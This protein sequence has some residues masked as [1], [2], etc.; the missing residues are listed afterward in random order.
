MDQPCPRLTGRNK[1]RLGDDR[2][3]VSIADRSGKRTTLTG[4][5]SGIQGLAWAPGGEEVWFTAGEARL[6]LRAVSLS[7]RQRLVTRAAGHLLIHDIAR[8]GRVLLTTYD[9]RA[10]TMGMAP[11]ETKERD[12]SSFEYSVLTDITPDGKKILYLE[13]GESGGS[14]YSV[15]LR[16]TDG[17]P[18]VRL[19]QGRSEGLSPDGKWALALLLTTPPQLTLL[20]TGVGEP[21][22]LSRDSIDYQRVWWFPDGKRLLV[23]GSEP[24]HGNRLYV[25]DLEGGKLQPV[26][27]E[28]IE[29]GVGQNILSPDGKWIAAGEAGK[30]ACLYPVEGGEPRP[31]PGIADGDAPIQWSDDGHS[32]FVRRW[33]ELPARIYRLDLASGRRDLWKQIMPGD[34]TGVVQIR[35]VLPARDGRAYAYSYMRILSQ[36]YVVEGLK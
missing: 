36:L 27:P 2:G 1:G 6:D 23:S 14:L 26:T 21:R 33:D 34:P 32:L 5:F 22:Q 28:R 13:P 35:G 25:R 18:P 24:G 3:T 19:G 30:K 12:L 7:G 10:A 20:P 11:N 8:D 15:L 17:S 16:R 9:R 31:I 29:V 4:E